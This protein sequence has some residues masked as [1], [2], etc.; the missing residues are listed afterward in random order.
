MHHAKQRCAP[1][2]AMH[3]VG[4]VVP[5][6]GLVVPPLTQC[7]AACSTSNN[8][9]CHRAHA[10]CAGPRRAGPARAAE[11]A[12]AVAGEGP[13]GLLAAAALVPVLG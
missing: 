12:D 13:S 2:T 9:V 6:Q 3:A 1:C 5:I 7:L 11:L 10:P 8:A 4:R